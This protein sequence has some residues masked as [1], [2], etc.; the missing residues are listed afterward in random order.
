MN[1]KD[2]CLITDPQP[3][4]AGSRLARSTVLVGSMT[5][6]S[7]VLG[8]LRDMVSAMW[9]GAGIENDAFLVA[10]KIPNFLRRLFAE[11][12]FSQAFIPILSEY[13]TQKSPEAVKNLLNHTAFVLG[14]VLLG[15]TLLGILAA[16][17]LVR[18]FAPGFSC[19]PEQ[20]DL[21][22]VLLRITF[23][24]LFFISLTAF[25][26]AILNSYDRFMAPAFTPVFLNIAMIVSVV[27][28]S[29]FFERPIMALACGVFIGGVLQLL[30]QMPFLARL[31]LL[32]RPAP[33]KDSVGVHRILKNMLPALLGVSVAQINLLI[34]TV[35]AS[36][37][38]KGSIS[39]LYYSDRL[40]EFP[41]GVF[42]VA[43]ATVVLPHLSRQHAQAL[44]HDFAHT[45]DWSLRT[46]LLIGTPASLGL[47]LLAEP[48][49]MSLFHYG[50]FTAI[51]VEKSGL[52]L[53]AFAVGLVAFVSVKILA[54]AY[55]AQKNIKTPVKI[56]MIALV[57]NVLFSLALIGF[58]KHVGLAIAATLSGFL[59]AG[60]LWAGLYRRGIYYAH[61]GSRIFLRQV[62]LANTLLAVIL[63]VLTPSSVFWLHHSAPMRLL[64]LAGLLC[65]AGLAYF[66]ALWLMRFDFKSHIRMHRA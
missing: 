18:L 33:G 53:K 26:G 38:P 42:G 2:P 47:Y 22:S 56:A 45:L 39:W 14:W 1:S 8:F 57:A 20:L 64:M 61:S 9:F 66:L 54:S 11:G 29:T 15:I 27:C 17:W 65:V 40:M 36:F 7:R 4:Q 34:D 6:I 25:F 23:P 51:D 5:V 48:I 55:Y 31:H 12:A 60:L 44:S 58:F 32:P 10:F 13:R 35:F 21:A 43:L 19:H 30:F 62:L 28:F 24:Y 41:L 59:N 50:N 37:L 63:I 46:I 16:P 52:S 3:L 49:V